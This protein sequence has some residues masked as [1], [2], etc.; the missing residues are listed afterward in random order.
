M[1]SV[2]RRVVTVLFADLAD[3]TGMTERLDAEDVARVQEAYFALAEA[4]VTAEAGLVEKFI[5]DAVMAT[6]GT[7]RAADDDALRAV[8]AGR[9]LVAAVADLDRRLGMAGALRVRVGV[10]TG[11]VVVT[12]RAGGW[13]VTGDT[14]NTAARL[15][16]AAEPGQVLVGPQTALA[17]EDDVDL[18]PAGDRALKGKAAP[19][20]TW[21][22]AP[23]P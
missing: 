14:V 4:A 15:Q 13:R 5:G 22:V 12:R 3:F 6:F 11:V 1:P 18:V 8:R 23:G 21:V 10:D 7:T 9:R 16:A 17:V 2:D 20:P 19:V